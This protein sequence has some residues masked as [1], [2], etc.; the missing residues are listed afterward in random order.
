MCCSLKSL[1]SLKLLWGRWLPQGWLLLVNPV[2]IGI[3]SIVW[4]GVLNFSEVLSFTHP[5]TWNT[6]RVKLSFRCI[7]SKVWDQMCVTLWKLECMFCTEPKKV[8][9]LCY[10]VISIIV[11]GSNKDFIYLILSYLCSSNTIT[12]IPVA[13]FAA[14]YVWPPYWS[15]LLLIKI[16]CM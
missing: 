4:W 1:I 11:S 10:F 2:A 6:H 9:L 3:S 5:H 12:S 7:M 14:L 15:K 8:L 13:Y 16:S